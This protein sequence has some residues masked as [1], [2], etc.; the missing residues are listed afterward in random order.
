MH[1]VSADRARAHVD[2]LMADHPDLNL[3]HIARLAGMGKSPFPTK[4]RWRGQITPDTEE[5]IL[6]VTDRHVHLLP[7]YHVDRRP[8]LAHIDYLLAEVEDSSLNLI[9]KT[10]G[11]SYQTMYNL[12]SGVS[13]RCRYETA[14][15]ILSVTP[16][17][18]REGVRRVPAEQSI[19]RIRSL[20]ANGWSR[21]ALDA[22]L[23]RMIAHRLTHSDRPTTVFVPLADRVK[24]VYDMIG[25]TPGPSTSAANHARALGF[26]PPIYYDEEMNLIEV[27]V[28]DA[29]A[30][31]ARDT[32]R[33][34]GLTLEGRSVAEIMEALDIAAD[35]KVSAAR[36]EH[37]LVITRT[38]AG[39]YVAAEAVPGIFAVIREALRPVHYRTDLDILD[40]PGTDYV[41]L[42]RTIREAVEDADSERAA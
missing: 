36:R 1:T 15:A 18:L 12:R 6:A 17:M 32:L 26:W 11:I 3:H 42:L 28:E 5:R 24:E 9:G 35:R 21:T 38:F 2:R 39:D 16:E 13:H 8:T 33:I 40:E 25:D 19:R 30:R 41:A 37:G 34:L 14:T 10:C 29:E 7:P 22:I 20:Q 4:K 23:G 27:E 31:A